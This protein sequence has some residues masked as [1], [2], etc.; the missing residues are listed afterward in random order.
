MDAGK[1]NLSLRAELADPFSGYTHVVVGRFA[2]GEFL[3]KT[4]VYEDI[5]E[6]GK[7]E[8]K[9]KDKAYIIC[10]FWE[11]RCEG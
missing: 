3:F 9:D 2:G 6:W 7:G 5:V 4:N 8:L 11:G 10:K 1:D